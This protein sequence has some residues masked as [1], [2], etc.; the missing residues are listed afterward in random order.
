MNQ[1]H[2]D[3]VCTS[4]ER[5][6]IFCSLVMSWAV[7]VVATTCFSTVKRRE[8][9][10]HYFTYWIEPSSKHYCTVA[11]IYPGDWTYGKHK[12][13]L[14]I[15]VWLSKALA[16]YSPSEL[17]VFSTYPASY[18]AGPLHTINIWYTVLLLFCFIFLSIPTWEA[19]P[20]LI[21]YRSVKH[22]FC[23]G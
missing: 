9:R 11:F 12:A 15:F 19:C 1:L 20:P 21:S 13:V 2:F 23:D 22:L 3:G 17:R 4:V 6:I 5:L 10:K 16:G 14:C 7:I 8:E 18:V